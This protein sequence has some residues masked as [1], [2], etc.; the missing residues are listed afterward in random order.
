MREKHGRLDLAF[1]GVFV[2]LHSFDCSLVSLGFT[3]DTFLDINLSSTS[4]RQQSTPLPIFLALVTTRG[5]SPWHGDG[6]SCNNLVIY[7]HKLHVQLGRDVMVGYF[8]HGGRMVMRTSAEDGALAFLLGMTG[9]RGVLAK[10]SRHA[11]IGHTSRPRSCP[12]RT[13]HRSR[14]APSNAVCG[15]ASGR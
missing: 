10:L 9:C 7:G 1:E 2:S 8:L 13:R 5:L 15:R 11:L 14:S 4:L 12:K 3:L 6:L